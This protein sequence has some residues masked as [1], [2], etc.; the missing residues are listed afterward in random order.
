MRK[1]FI[2]LSGICVGLAIYW[3]VGDYLAGELTDDTISAMVMIILIG[4]VF[5][6][7]AWLWGGPVERT[8]EQAKQVVKKVQENNEENQELPPALKARMWKYRIIGGLVCIFSIWIWVHWNWHEI[9][10]SIG[11]V[12]LII[13]IAI[14]MMGSPGD[15]NSITDTGAMIAMDKPRTIEEFYEAFKNIKT[16]LG[17]G[18]LGNFYTSPYTSL[19]FGPDYRGQFVYFWLNKDGNIGYTGYSFLT[20]AI[21]E[22]INEPVFFP[23]D[24]PSLDL[25]QNLC[26]HSDTFLFQT[27]L[28]DSIENLVKKG[29]ILPFVESKPSQVY[30]FTEDFKLT[31]Q[32]FELHDQ[33]DEMIY[34]IDGAAP[35]INL[36]IYDANHTEIFK[37]TKE[38]GHALAT[39]RFYYQGELYGVL[40][41]QFTFVRDH[42]V[43]EVK[44]GKLELIEYAGTIGRNFRVLLNGKML[45]SIMDNME[46]KIRNIVFDNAFLIVYEK[47]YLPLLT[48]MAVMVAREIARD[49]E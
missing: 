30:T 12:V 17:S 41:K 8:T 33:N 14:F 7:L 29:E 35:L 48:A 5:G 31:G 36:Y 38:I 42:F 37:L 19:I 49:E 34:E 47:D 16:P 25:A 46:L 32:H 18:W 24:E 20:D 3:G 27:W 45:G 1:I 13:G 2:I 43:M 44:E 22:K 26:Y 21:K 40:E 6:F 39:Y 9:P 28:K 15:Y 11:T 4:A 23:Q 10:V